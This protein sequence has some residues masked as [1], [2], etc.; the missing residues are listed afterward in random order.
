M[1]NGIHLAILAL[2]RMGAAICRR[3]RLALSGFELT[4]GPALV[5][6][7][8]LRVAH[9]RAARHVGLLN[10]VLSPETRGSLTSVGLC[11]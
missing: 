5:G 9:L 11:L 10:L 1:A 3:V 7:K 8:V 2:N 4:G 6:E